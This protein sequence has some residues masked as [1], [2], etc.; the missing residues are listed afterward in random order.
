MLF[1]ELRKVFPLREGNDLATEILDIWLDVDR[2]RRPFVVV[3]L[4]NAPAGISVSD[5]DDVADFEPIARDVDRIAVHI[6][7]AM[8]HNLAGL[9]D[10]IGPAHSENDGLE[11]EFE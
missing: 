7:M 3:A 10:R 1:E 8:R 9:V 5:L 11:P 4:G 2:N 6:D